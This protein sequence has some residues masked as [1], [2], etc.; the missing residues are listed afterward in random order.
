MSTIER[1]KVTEVSKIIMS[2]TSINKM[3][4]AFAYLR[5]I[6]LHL[7]TIIILKLKSQQLFRTI[8]STTTKVRMEIKR[9]LE[10]NSN[11]RTNEI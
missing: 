3:R 4:I 6:I 1:T 5:N 7:K 10:I 9:V 11:I 2:T 8:H